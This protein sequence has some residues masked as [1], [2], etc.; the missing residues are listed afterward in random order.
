MYESSKNVVKDKSED[1][2]IEVIEIYKYLTA[3][4]KEYVLSKQLLRSATSIGAM[5]CEAEYAESKADFIH[6]FSIAQK[7]NNETLYW[8]R[9]CVKADFMKKSDFEK[10][11]SNATELIKL[12]TKII[13]TSKNNLKRK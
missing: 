9:L 3:V 5:I 2:S 11:Y 7:E 10:L 13:V 12:I 8:L 6:K 4:K 1:F